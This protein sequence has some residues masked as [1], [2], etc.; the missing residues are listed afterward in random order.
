[1]WKS[2]SCIHYLDYYIGCEKFPSYH[3]FTSP[4]L[5]KVCS[6]VFSYQEVQVPH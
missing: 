2:V 4:V 6:Y 5:M 1:M 3:C